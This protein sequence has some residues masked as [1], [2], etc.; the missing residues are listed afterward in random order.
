VSFSVAV[1]KDQHSTEFSVMPIEL[2][3]PLDKKRARI[4]SGKVKSANAEQAIEIT[5]TVIKIQSDYICIGR[6]LRIGT[7]GD[8][9]RIDH[10]LGQAWRTSLPGS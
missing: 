5:D 3:A 6:L 10:S 9:G 4:L 2:I 1:L 8:Y 7:R